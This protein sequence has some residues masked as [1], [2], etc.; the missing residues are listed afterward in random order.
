MLDIY[1]TTLQDVDAHNQAGTLAEIA[2][3][4]ITLT[5]EKNDK[6]DASGRVTLDKLNI[7]D[8]EGGEAACFKFY[9]FIGTYEG[10]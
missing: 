4:F 2:S 8:V 3:S 5:G 10:G 6:T 9:F 7:M 1:T